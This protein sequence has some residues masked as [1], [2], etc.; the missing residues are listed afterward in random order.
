MLLKI[1]VRICPSFW[2]QMALFR[3]LAHGLFR[4]VFLL[5][6]ALIETAHD[7]KHPKKCSASSAITSKVAKN[8]TLCVVINSKVISRFWKCGKTWSRVFDMLCIPFGKFKK[9]PGRFSKPRPY[10]SSHKY[11]C[12]HTSCVISILSLNDSKN[13]RLR[14]PFSSTIKVML[15]LSTQSAVSK[16]LHSYNP[17]CL[18][19]AL[20]ISSTIVM[21]S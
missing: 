3:V 9:F 19:E 14:L 20:I 13:T 17:L 15:L 7:V 21:R 11:T 10:I 1:S 8:T 18:S 2:Y 4:P 16:M 12:D 6:L 5:V